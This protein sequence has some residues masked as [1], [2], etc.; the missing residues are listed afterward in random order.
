MNQ[1]TSQGCG[2]CKPSII[3]TLLDQDA[4]S[5]VIGDSITD[6]EAAKLGMSLLQEI[7]SLKNV[8]N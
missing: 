1:C 6:L 7:S 3:R 4:V 2:C 5:V 8:R